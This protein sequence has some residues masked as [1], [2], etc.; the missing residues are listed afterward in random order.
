MARGNWDIVARQ[1]HGY[2]PLV[3]LFW[4]SKTSKLRTWL[5]RGAERE[6]GRAPST[7]ADP[8][9]GRDRLCVP[10]LIDPSKYT[11]SV[12]EARVSPAYFASQL[13]GRQRACGVEQQD[14]VS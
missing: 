13:R 1:C 2:G 7:E 11:R 10:T 5:E 4:L 9:H 14:S 3:Y 8:G 6:Q 12:K